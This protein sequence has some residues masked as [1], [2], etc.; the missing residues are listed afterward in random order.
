MINWYDPAKPR[1]TTGAAPAPSAR[2]QTNQAVFSS[3]NAGGAG[4]EYKVGNLTPTQLLDPSLG[5]GDTFLA[6]AKKGQLEALLGGMSQANPEDYKSLDMLRNYY[7]GALADLP[8]QTSNQIS[9]FDTQ[10]QRGLSNLLSQY[11]T[12]NPNAVGTRQFAGAQGDI[13]SRA[14]SDYMTGLMNARSNAIGQANAIQNGLTGV[15]NQNFNERQFQYGQGK[16]LADL[17]ST[18]VNQEMG[19]PQKQEESSDWLGSV[20]PA[21]GLAAGALIPGVGPALGLAAGSTLGGIAGGSGAGQNTMGLAQLLQNQQLIGQ[22][23]QYP[24]GYYGYGGPSP[25]ADSLQNQ[26]NSMRTY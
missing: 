8:G 23:Q 21:A 13:V 25:I 15:Q 18:M 26:F 7:Q 12:Q 24:Q 4:G 6:S 19:R 11:K 3:G 22:R 9:S 5:F 10:S 2:P 20:L 17:L 1:T 14:T 16:G